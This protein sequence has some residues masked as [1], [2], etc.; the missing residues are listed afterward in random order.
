[1]LAWGARET[2]PITGTGFRLTLLQNFA[3]NQ[4]CAVGTTLQWLECQSF[5]LRAFQ[6]GNGALSVCTFAMIE[7][8]IE[9]REIQREVLFAHLM[10]RASDAALQQR[11]LGFNGICMDVEIAVLPCVFLLRVAD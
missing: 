7:A 3:M 2:G 11:E 1:M 6:G 9:F 4:L 5:A 10:E 8:V